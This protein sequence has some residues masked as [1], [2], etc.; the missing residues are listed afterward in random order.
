MTREETV[1]IIR[2]MVDSYPNFKPNNISET[3]DVWQMMLSDY[4]YNLVAMALKAYILSDTSGFA[5]SIGQL[6]GKI[7]TLTKPQEL[8]EMEAWALVCDAL[9][10]CGY[11]YS[12][13]YAKL[14]PL[15]QKA[16]GLPSQLQTWALTENLN[17]DVV[18]SNFMRCYR[19]EV[20]RQKEIS[21]MPQN[22]KELLEKISSESHSFQ[23]EQKREHSVKSLVDM[24]EME[25]KEL[26]EQR[27]CVPMP[28][29]VKKRMDDWKNNKRTD[30]YVG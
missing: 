16:V 8:N 3:V 7:Q 28:A 27:E 25:S 14:P 4:D 18:G 6:V 1:K 20:E 26:G 19:I 13:E 23:I 30:N 29:D 10:S 11:N 9:S 2:I 22:V 21:K 15:V 17:K 5:P 12:E 24:K